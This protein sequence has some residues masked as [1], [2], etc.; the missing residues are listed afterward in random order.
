LRSVW[1]KSR[2]P[3]QQTVL[4]FVTRINENPVLSGI[5]EWER[6]RQYAVGKSKDKKA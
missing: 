1:A 5:P 2:I 3:S 4:A 6:Y